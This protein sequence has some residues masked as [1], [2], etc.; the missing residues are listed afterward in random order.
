MNSSCAPLVTKSKIP[1]LRAPPW[2]GRVGRPRKDS[3]QARLPLEGRE[4][5]LKERDRLALRMGL[6]RDLTTTTAWGDGDDAGPIRDLLSAA[7]V[8]DGTVDHAEHI[9]VEALYETVP[10]LRNATE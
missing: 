4:A 8:A 3:A 9:T 5:G 10:Q 2:A 7:V 1:I 6:L